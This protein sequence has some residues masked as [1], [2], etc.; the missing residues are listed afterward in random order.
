MPN[1]KKAGSYTRVFTVV[2]VIVIV[3]V[4]RDSDND[5]DSDSDSVCDSDLHPLSKA[6]AL[7]TFAHE[8]GYKGNITQNFRKI[9]V[10]VPSVENISLLILCNDARAKR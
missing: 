9:V 10:K 7:I 4:I 5:S 8:V 3:I 6:L 1:S 2:I